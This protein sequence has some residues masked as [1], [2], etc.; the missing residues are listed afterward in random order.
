MDQQW[1]SDHQLATTVLE[2]TYHQQHMLPSHL[3]DEDTEAPSEVH[4]LGLYF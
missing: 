3:S 1:S 4:N 2:T